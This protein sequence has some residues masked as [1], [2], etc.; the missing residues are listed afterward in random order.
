MILENNTHIQSDTRN[1][2]FLLSVGKTK[3]LI[4]SELFANNITPTFNFVLEGTS[5]QDLLRSRG[6]VFWSIKNNIPEITLQTSPKVAFDVD[7]KSPELVNTT[8][9]KTFGSSTKNITLIANKNMFKLDPGHVPIM[10]STY[11]P[12][13]W[14]S[15]I[16]K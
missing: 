3:Q 15:F 12:E 10:R 9:L 16:I 5:I 6:G 13:Y 2:N 11:N 7:I 8:T 1:T 14:K 4:N